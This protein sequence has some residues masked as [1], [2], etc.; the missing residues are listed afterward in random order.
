ML[1]VP[2]CPGSSKKWNAHAPSCPMALLPM[3]VMTI[4]AT[5]SHKIS[6]NYCQKHCSDNG[7]SVVQNIFVYIAL[8]DCM[9]K[10]WHVLS[11]IFHR[12]KELTQM[13]L[14]AHCMMFCMIHIIASLG[15]LIFWK[16]LIYAESV[17]TVILVTMQVSG[18]LF[19]R[20]N[21]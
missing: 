21:L 1:P 11:I 5:M 8:M 14:P 7:C 2:P 4:I 3:S 18:C 16:A 15:I 19:I 20:F 17:L 12:F 10:S 13:L 6:L 9:D